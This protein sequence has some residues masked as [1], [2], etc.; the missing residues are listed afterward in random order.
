MWLIVPSSEL[1]KER[2]R[3]VVLGCCHSS[4]DLSAPSILLPWVRLPSMSS[5]LFSF[6]VKF[7]LYLSMQCEKRTKINKKRDRVWPIFYDQQDSVFWLLVCQFI[8]FQF[9]LPLP[10]PDQPTYCVFYYTQCDQIGQFIAFWVTFQSLWQQLFCPNCPHVQAIFVKWS[11]SFILL[12]KSFWA[13]FIDSLPI[14]Y[15]S[16]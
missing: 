4:V 12:V 6:T 2:Q 11:K 8:T 9:C 10:C 14:F 15:L 3:S 1:D 5:M 13:T 7:V 16:H